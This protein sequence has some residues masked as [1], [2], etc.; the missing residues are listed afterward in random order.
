MLSEGTINKYY[1]DDRV[2]TYV[3][4]TG[5]TTSNAV[6]SIVDS[7]NYITLDEVPET[8]LTNYTT[9]E[10]VGSIVENCNYITLDEVPETD[11]TNY[12]TFENVGSIVESCNYITIDDVPETDLTNYTT[13]ENVG[14]IVESCNYITIDEVPITPSL[15]TDNTN[16]ITYGNV[17]IY[18]NKITIGVT[19]TESSPI[20]KYPREPLTDLSTTYTDGTVV[21]VVASSETSG[22]RVFHSFDNILISNSP[23]FGWSSASSRYST[24]TGIANT[25]HRTEYAGE[26]FI[27]DLGEQIIL[28]Y[29]KIYPRIELPKKCPKEFRIYASNSASSY[30]DINDSGWVQIFEGIDTS[31]GSQTTPYTYTIANTNQYK[32]YTMVINKKF[33]SS[34]TSVQFAE[35]EFY[36][37]PTVLKYPRELSQTAQTVNNQQISY[38]DGTVVK[39]K[40]STVY[41]TASS[42]SYRPSNL[43][44]G[45]KTGTGWVGWSSGNTG[46]PS[47]SSSTGEAIYTY[48]DDGYA[49]EWLMID[50]GEQIFLQNIN[51][52]PETN[53]N[54]RQPR[55]FRIYAS[56][57][58]NAYDNGVNDSEW[59]LINER[60][61]DVNDIANNNMKIY[62]IQSSSQYRYYYIVIN[63]T[64]NGIYAHFAELEFYGK[65]AQTLVQLATLDDVGSIVESCNYITLDEV[66]ETDLTNY[67]TFENVGSIVESCNY[68]TI[69]DFNTDDIAVGTNSKFIVNNVYDNDLFVVGD[70]TTSNLRVIGET[71]VIDTFEYTAEKL[72]IINDNYQGAALR[73]DNYSSIT[74]DLFSAWNYQETGGTITSNSLMMI[75]SDGKIGVGTPTPQHTLDVVGDIFTSGDIRVSNIY[76]S[77]FYG[78]G[79]NL[80][81]VNLQNR[82]TDMLSEGTTN[83]YYTDD[84]VETYVQSTGYTTSN[85][86]R[87]II[88]SCNYITIDEVPETDLTNYTTFENVGSIVE[89]CNYITIDEVPITPSFFT[90]YT[91]YISYRDVNIYDDKIT[92]GRAAPFVQPTIINNG[93]ST[94]PIQI[95][96]TND[97]YF[98]FTSTSGVN[99]IEFL[100]D[101]ECEIL[102]VA[103]GGGGAGGIGG[104][105]GGG[106]VIH[107]PVAT[108]PS[109]NTT[110][111]VG[112]G[113][114]TSSS[115]SSNGDDSK[116]ITST[117][118]EIIAKGGGGVTAGYSYGDGRDGGSGGGGSAPIN[119]FNT[120]GNVS[121]DSTLGTFT[122]SIYG[123]KGGGNTTTRTQMY[124]G[125]TNASG[126]G[127]AGTA[128]PNINPNNQLGYGGDGILI[129]IDGNNSYWGG[130]GGGAIYSFSGTP[131]GGIGGGGNGSAN[132]GGNG[133]ANTG[134]GGGG[135]GLNYQGGT[136]GSGI[137]IIRWKIPDPPVQLATIDDIS[138]SE[139]QWTGTNPIIANSKI[140]IIESTGTAASANNGTIILDHENGGG[141]SSI[142]F[143][144]KVN[145]GSDYGY[146]QYQDNSS[147][148]TSGENAILT[149]GTQNDADDNIAIMP[150]G[151]CGINTTAPSRKL[152][153]NGETLISN[154]LVIQY[155]NPTLYLKDTN[156]YSSMI[157]CNSNRLYVLRGYTNTETWTAYNGRWPLQFDLLNNNATFGGLN[158][159]A[160]NSYYW[161]I[162]SDER[163]KENIEEANYE[164]CYNNINN[165]ALKRFKY[166]DGLNKDT[167]DKYRL[168]YIA[169]DVQKIFPKNVFVEPVSIYNSSNVVI[170]EIKDCL[171]LDAEQISMS[172]YGAFKHAMKKIEKLEKDNIDIL[173]RLTNLEGAL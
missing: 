105:G 116:L 99:S 168:G 6:R 73:I 154:K 50:L 39:F 32:Y 36:G 121:T 19:N 57:S 74:G 92:I 117:S 11:L 149:I 128:A 60:L 83:K 107:I 26:Y 71:T 30:S 25:T 131:A 101:T 23:N 4:S 113:G 42:N 137:V 51:V 78:S 52:Y 152:H 148:A 166:K 27:I 96:G 63:K 93:T 81:S 122:G 8:D 62:N 153:V 33:V 54:K 98:S 65:S 10:N 2:E 5:Y 145:R 75:Q 140:Q 67:T 119:Q 118:I 72:H 171:A 123:N 104:G 126:G 47:Y 110:I 151:N 48:K 169:Q 150:S 37:R 58:Q 95:T 77:N 61:S 21:N 56:N 172:L 7:C 127:G 79:E 112:N 130:G 161:A 41:E 143:R 49:G 146:I 114:T 111:I 3:Q 40:A 158:Y 129:N 102:I 17:N 46:N 1:T 120:G 34:D 165:L 164:L 80:H 157:H 87:S 89:S 82:D 115:A 84:R 43:F 109:G 162:N 69:N 94:T 160:N 64:Y 136:G 134:G 20:I 155:D 147:G 85:D 55:Q 125:T 135:G 38:T 68:I 97:Y 15:F 159:Q 106:A 76:A 163:I 13:F 59:V 103:G 28:D 100:E 12:T 14:S 18:D 90:D 133:V 124:S 108:L 44:D 138:S 144:S 173:A 142:V 24:S 156:G 53:D 132:T 86:V 91:D 16:Y 29:I 170:E 66:P 70:L 22:R 88:D 31:D 45:I 141:K 167:Y 35:L 9:F 139:S